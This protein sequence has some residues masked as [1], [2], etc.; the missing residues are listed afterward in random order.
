MSAPSYESF[1]GLTARPFS[2]APDPRFYFR[3]RSHGR[4]LETVTFG[5]RRGDRFLL[6]TGDLGVG[7][8]VLC[9][10]LVEQLR[11]RG[12]VSCIGNPLMTAESFVRVLHEDLG[13]V[14][15][16]EPPD[17]LGAPSI[18]ALHDRLRGLLNYPDDVRGSSVVVIDEAHTLPAGLIDH[19]LRLA[20]GDHQ[21][22]P[23]VQI[24]LVGESIAREHDALG[25]ALLDEH[26]ATKARLLPL[27][28]DECTEYVGHRLAI[29]GGADRAS[30]SPRAIDTLYGLSGGVPRLVNL[31]CERALQ[32]AA[33][34]NSLR[35]ESAAI[36]ASA[37]A[38]QLL[39]SRP[40]RFRWYSRRVS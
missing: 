34:G 39:R 6:V 40:R 18:H 38:L 11:R 24:V 28:R 10:T 16:E 30:F 20:R 4:A 33:A 17:P 13:G 37:S 32:E 36:E 14:P 1:F 12:P 3:S 26:V 23:L 21:R 27:S 25:I 19:L 2:L 31:L 5:L 29:A 9:R 35:I 7:K 15:P 22:E 8:T